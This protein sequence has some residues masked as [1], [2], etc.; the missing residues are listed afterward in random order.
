[1][2]LL[3]AVIFAFLVVLIWSIIGGVVVFWLDH[4]YYGGTDENPGRL[5]QWVNSAPANSSILALWIWPVL[6]I[7]AYKHRGDK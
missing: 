1:M 2:G 7:D 5:V 6:I 4:K 3:Q